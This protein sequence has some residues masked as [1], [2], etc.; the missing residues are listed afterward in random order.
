VTGV[1]VVSALGPNATTSFDRL[2]RGEVGIRPVT[3]FDTSEQRCRLAAEVD[4]DRLDVGPARPECSRTDRM[5]LAAAHE[6]LGHAGLRPGA[7]PISVVVGGTTGGM[8]EAERTL[9]ERR[10]GG[11][12]PDLRPLLS[13]PLSTC[14]DALARRFAPVAR[15]VTLCSACSSGSNALVVAAAWIRSGRARV[16]LAGAS[17]GLCRLTFTG[18]SSLG[19][20]SPDPCRPF[21][22]ERRGLSL[23]EGAAFVVL[24][25][26][27]AARERGAP[28]LAFLDGYAVAAEAYHI[29]HPEPSAETATGLIESALARAG[30]AP[31]EIDYVNAHGT[32][33]PQND[34]TEARALADALGG[35]L[36]RIY[37]S[38]SKGQIGHTLGTAG[39]IGAVFTVLAIAR[40]IVPPSGGLVTPDPALPLRHVLATGCHADLGAALSSSFGFGGT[41]AVLAFSS[42]KR[43]ALLSPASAI[44][45]LFVTAANAVGDFGALRGADLAGALGAATDTPAQSHDWVAELDPARSRRFDRASALITHGAGQA[46]GDARHDAK[47]VGLVAGSAFGNVER[48]VDFLRRVFERG[49]R[50]APPAEFPHLVPSGPAGN[51]SIYLGLKGPVLSVSDLGTSAEAALGVGA[52]FLELGLG[53]A[54]V[55]GSAEPADAVIEQVLSPIWERER[56][57]ARG[58]GEGA[59]WLL[60]EAEPTERGARRLAELVAWQTGGRADTLAPPENPER[61]LVLGKSSPELDDFLSGSAWERVSRRSVHELGVPREVLGGVLLAVAVGLVAACRHDSVLVV[62]PGATNVHAFVFG[63]P[64]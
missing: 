57:S 34:S 61:A 35:E 12:P 32:A 42:A 45:R 11:E 46:L 52:S 22:A 36:E 31:N 19:V 50:F 18:F 58:R 28:I 44:P 55:V 8:F 39:A 5:A 21:D 56:G 63:V 9:A 14:A 30:L 17:E 41:G 47:T 59:A 49:A 24:E 37:V 48:S 16:V 64:S 62:S 6:A 23:G 2:V 54:F 15:A 13:Y 33:T 53:S 38:S 26:E 27:E 4:V 1:G 7:E 25:P 43:R 20:M 3:L 10:P 60:I 51:A 40:G 29:T